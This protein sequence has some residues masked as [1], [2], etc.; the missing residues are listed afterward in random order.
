MTQTL[1]E[2][3]KDT[4]VE[5]FRQALSEDED[6]FRPLIQTVVQE[7]LEEEMNEAIG[8]RKGE[9]TMGRLSYRSGYYPRTLVTR[10][11]K[12]E[13]KVPQ[14]RQGRFCTAIFE[15]YQRSEKAL[16]TALIEMYIQGVSTRKVGAVAEQ[17]CGH[18]FSASTISRLNKTLDEELEHFAHRR[19]CEEYPYVILDARYEKVRS[20]GLINPN[21]VLIAVGINWDG[22]REILGVEIA[23]RES[24]TSWKQFLL[25][26]KKR[27]LHGVRL[28]ITDNHEG[29]KNA[30][31]EIFPE[32]AWQRCYVHFLCNARDRL[33]RKGDDDC[34]QELRW[35]Y[36]RRDRQE[37][38]RDL[39]AW[40]ERWAA[41][42]PKLVDWAEEH[43]E[44]TLAFYRF[45]KAHHKHIKSTNMLE[46]LNQE[47]KRRSHVVRIFPNEASCLRLI[48]A[49]C[50]ETHEKWI[51]AHRYLNMIHLR[52]HLKTALQ[53]QAA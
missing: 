35:I 21:A 26:L 45:P 51:E 10:V 4:L 25:A 29:L 9:R 43:I 47:I 19:L 16:V 18:Q 3:Q 28:A 14:D 15:R 2:E 53:D 37:A 8:A 12:I 41:R 20:D 31:R 49:L 27:G 30:L 7:L 17:L 36:D 50:V 23:N 11:G 44:E 38:C 6:V 42:Y 48:R 5:Q 1:K 34:M 40:I 13:L 22:R 24:R 52:D 39:K 46:R 32:T 33:P